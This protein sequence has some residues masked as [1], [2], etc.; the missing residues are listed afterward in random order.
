MKL[1]RE[2]IYEKFTQDSDPITNMSIG[3]KVK[4]EKLLKGNYHLKWEFPEQKDYIRIK[5]IQAKSNGNPEKERMYA[6]NMAAAIEDRY[7]AY[8]RYLAAKEIG[9]EEWDVTMIFLQKVLEIWKVL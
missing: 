3:L 7:K 2:H 6:R 8:R 4:L 1:V 9:G 5:N